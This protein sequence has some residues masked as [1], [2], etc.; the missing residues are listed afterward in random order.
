ML[1][2]PWEYQLIMGSHL[3]K[4]KTEKEISSGDGNELKWGCC[5]MQGWRTSM[6]DAHIHVV[7]TYC[8]E[9]FSSIP[10]ISAL[11]SFGA[12]CSFLFQASLSDD[13]KQ[14]SLF[15]VFDGHSG[16]Q[17]ADKIANNYTNFLLTQ[18]PFSTLKDG[19][20]YEPSDISK[21]LVINDHY[22][23]F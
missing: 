7:N 19:D 15:F 1:R 3:Q 10:K 17:F 8:S 20:P 2:N 21:D 16:S 14:F 12:L 23:S 18:D 9:N 22:D 6:E 5:G 11:C 13:L 4:P